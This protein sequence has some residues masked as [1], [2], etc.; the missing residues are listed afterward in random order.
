MVIPDFDV[1]LE[2]LYTKLTIIFMFQV[3]GLSSW[4]ARAAILG[5]TQVMVFC[6]LFLVQDPQ[7]KQ[8]IRHLVVGLLCD[9]Q[10]EVSD[11][12]PLHIFY[13][14]ETTFKPEVTLWVGYFPILLILGVY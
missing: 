6:N 1:T 9:D 4:H 5:Y 8:Q 14:S 12:L 2:I 3:A 7:L 10:L 11:D 13:T